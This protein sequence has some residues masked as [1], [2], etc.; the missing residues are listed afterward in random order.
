M[1]DVEHDP[2]RRVKVY[3]LDSDLSWEEQGVGY[4][5]LV[6]NDSLGG[7]CI[8]VQSED[9]GE[10]LLET[11][12]ISNSTADDV[13]KKQQETLLVW[14]EPDGRDLALSFQE[15]SGCDDMLQK[16]LRA[17]S[18]MFICWIRKKLLHT[19]YFSY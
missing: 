13:Y 18:G 1:A 3:I 12:I 15:K 17:Q 6:N 8:H 7:M 9:S 10:A 5:T 4:V 16:I 2:K 14:E 11:R 19:T